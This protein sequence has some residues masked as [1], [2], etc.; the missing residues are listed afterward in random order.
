MKQVK[1]IAGD[2]AAGTYGYTNIK[3]QADKGEIRFTADVA[4]YHLTPE[5]DIEIVLKDGR[6]FT[7]E[8]NDDFCN[9]LTVSQNSIA[10]VMPKSADGFLRKAAGGVGLS[11]PA[12]KQYTTRPS[13]IFRRPCCFKLFIQY[14]P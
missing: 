11:R 9:V 5:R 10:S 8:K 3:M 6:R 13:E 12:I 7:V 2:L 14:F 1:V 4:S